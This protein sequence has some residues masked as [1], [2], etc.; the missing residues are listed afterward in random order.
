MGISNLRTTLALQI[1]G[2]IACR[3]ALVLFSKVSLAYGCRHLLPQPQMQISSSNEFL[4]NNL[5][6]SNTSLKEALGKFI[7][8]NEQ[9][10]MFTIGMLTITN[11]TEKKIIITKTKTNQI[12]NK[13]KTNIKNLKPTEK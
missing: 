5:R 11:D 12:L 1:L 10:E 2:G 4:M 6:K 7:R 8:P 3:R 9:Q 13:T